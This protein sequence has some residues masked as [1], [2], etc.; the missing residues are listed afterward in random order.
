VVY[1]L[2][3]SFKYLEAYPDSA[4]NL[5]STPIWFCS[6]YS[7]QLALDGALDAVRDALK[8]ILV[9]LTVRFDVKHFDRDMCISKG[10][11]LTHFDYVQHADAVS[12]S[13]GSLVEFETHRGIAENFILEL[14]DFDENP[15]RAAWLVELVRAIDDAN[16]PPSIP[17]VREIATDTRLLRRAFGVAQSSQQ[18]ANCS[19]TESVL[20]FV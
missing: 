13:L 17:L 3:L 5:C 6:K 18:I 8:R 9:I 4:L 15:T 7:E 19:P 1:F 10:W 14:L 11:R 12:Q 20:I 16:A 2:P